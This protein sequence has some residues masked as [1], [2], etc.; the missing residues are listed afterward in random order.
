MKTILGL[1]CAAV[2][3]SAATPAL[4]GHD[5]NPY[6]LAAQARAVAGEL[7]AL[8][9]PHA[10]QCNRWAAVQGASGNALIAIDRIEAALASGDSRTA[11]AMTERL[12]QI[13]DN[14]ENLTHDIARRPS[15]Y[16]GACPNTIRRAIGLSDALEDLAGD[17]CHAVTRFDWNAVPVVVTPAPCGYGSP[18]GTIPNA[19]YGSG[20]PSGQGYG[21]SGYGYGYGYGSSQG[22]YQ[23]GGYN[24]GS[25]VTPNHGRATV[26]PAGQYDDPRNDGPR[27]IPQGGPVLTRPS[28]GVSFRFGRW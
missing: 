4:A 1:L 15:A 21:N 6:R 16:T 14:L 28:V 11:D 27:L 12:E 13:G 20:Y 7:N 9:G 18:R 10:R 26:P 2:T 3:T 24:P 8:A 25:N 17:L 22:G 19:C 23:N 5:H